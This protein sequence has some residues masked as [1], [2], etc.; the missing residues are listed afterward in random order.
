MMFLSPIAQCEQL[1]EYVIDITLS[2]SES[3]EYLSSLIRTSQSRRAHFH[4]LELFRKERARNRNFTQSPTHRLS[5]D[6]LGAIF[7]YICL[8]RPKKAW[9]RPFCPTALGSICSY[10]HHVAW[11]TPRLWTRIRL[12]YTFWRGVG[13]NRLVQLYIQNSQ[14]MGL[15]IEI[16]N[17]PTADGREGSLGIPGGDV[18]DTI[19]VRN[20]HKLESLEF[21]V[22]VETWLFLIREISRLGRLTNLRN[23]RVKDSRD[24][25]PVAGTSFSIYKVCA[26]R[27]MTLDG[28][29]GPFTCPWPQLV[30]LTLAVVSS[31]D[32]FAAIQYCSNLES[33][34]CQHLIH[35]DIWQPDIIPNFVQTFPHLEKIVW[36]ST[37]PLSPLWNEALTHWF[38][39]PSLRTL[40]FNMPIIVVKQASSF[41]FNLPRSISS[42]SLRVDLRNEVQ[43]RVTKSLGSVKDINILHRVLSLTPLL[44]ILTLQCDLFF[45]PELMD[46]LTLRGAPTDLVPALRELVLVMS[47]PW[48]PEASTMFLKM[49]SSRRLR[50]GSDIQQLDVVGLI[51]PNTKNI[52][53]WP[54]VFIDVMRELVQQGLNVVVNVQAE[55]LVDIDWSAPYR[56]AE[57]QEAESAS[58]CEL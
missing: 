18:F 7:E 15:H 46:L 54:R 41:L 55:G 10:W 14:R 40:I 21:C 35:Q 5:P 13:R 2:G 4:S 57:E 26:L 38:Q 37:V 8:S 43:N 20:P 28:L 3:T 52:E 9:Q 34:R 16:R 32:A 51:V 39:F 48:S 1:P 31:D 58:S 19:F 30:H 6:I 12:D 45:D 33:L 22:Y 25:I 23:M 11:S 56:S 24:L 27:E 44:S 17:S 47:S 42:L 29:G 36:E 50:R 53:R 49:V